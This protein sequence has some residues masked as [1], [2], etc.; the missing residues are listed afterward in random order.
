M[1]TSTWGPSPDRHPS[2]LNKG[3]CVASQGKDV[4]A[5]KSRACSVQRS[6]DCQKRDKRA[7]PTH[8]NRT[9]TV[10]GGVFCKS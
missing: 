7:M 5:M 8:T 1:F 4:A 6:R 3:L 9:S 2:S 10:E